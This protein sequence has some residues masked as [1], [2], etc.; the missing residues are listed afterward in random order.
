MSKPSALRLGVLGTLIIAACTASDPVS[1]DHPE[2]P[3]DAPPE[4]GAAPPDTG[5]GE[6]D[7]AS[8]PPD[9]SDAASS[10]PDASTDSGPAAPTSTDQIKNGDETDV[11]CGGP[12][13]APRCGTDKTC[14]AG[15]DCTDKIC[16]SGHCAPPS[17]TDTEKNGS[18]TD[19]NCGGDGTKEHA[20]AAGK[21]CKVH[22]DCASNGCD[23]AGRCAPRPSCTSKN[24][25]DTCLKADGTTES[26]CTSIVVPA[27]KIDTRDIASFTVD[28]Y[29][30]TAG[31]MRAFLDRVN[32]DVRGWMTNNAPAWW[33]PRWTPWLPSSFNGHVDNDY[34][35]AIGTTS[36]LGW[37]TGEDP[38]AIAA[39]ALAV[40]NIN[41]ESAW[42][43][44]AGGVIFDQGSQ[45]CFIGADSYGHPT[46]LVP[47]ADAAEIYGDDYQRWIGADAL[48]QRP[49]NCTNWPV[50]AALCA[51]DGGS[52]IST[53]QYDFI[54][55]D[56]GFTADTKNRSLY[57]WGSPPSLVCSSGVV[58]QYGACCKTPGFTKDKYSANVCTNG[59]GTW[60]A[61]A[62]G[63]DPVN[64]PHPGGYASLG[65]DWVL[66]GTGR[67]GFSSNPCADCVDD[68]VNWQFSYQDPKLDP[69]AAMLSPTE[70]DRRSRDQSYFISVP[71]AFPKGASRPF[72]GDPNQRVQDIAGLVF[73]AV[74]QSK[75]ATFKQQTITFGDEDASNDIVV[76]VPSIS[77]GTGGSWEG[78]AI[79]TG[80]GYPLPTKY[81]KMGLRCVYA[82]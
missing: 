16:T 59:G 53:D 80:A 55:D 46:F 13:T 77:T 8:S 22:S 20:C 43:Q 15:T 58:D 12:G 81:G 24:G 33:D 62:T 32:G 31:R 49:L 23:Y 74:T 36:V 78:H 19:L 54:Y 72:N 56:D 50:M 51:F 40:S 66:V 79:G 64:N 68:W 3:S 9:E 47:Q 1:P 48:D 52:L 11:D 35:K 71:G 21:S 17:Y 10:P 14:V 61:P 76:S 2:G 69:F 5:G 37:S 44:V 65:N 7:G 41:I 28:K 26:C 67:V 39:H 57:P 45:G 63:Y 70:Q 60:S 4:A 73:N 82:P 38:K 25:G 29:V 30:G 42:A 75:T 34:K 18:E 6:S 27:G